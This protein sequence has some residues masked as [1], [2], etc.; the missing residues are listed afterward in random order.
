MAESKLVSTKA[1]RG[2]HGATGQPAEYYIQS[3]GPTPADVVESIDRAF[4]VIERAALATITQMENAEP[5][6]NFN[7]FTEAMASLAEFGVVSKRPGV[8]PILKFTDLKQHKSNKKVE[9]APKVA[10]YLLAI[11]AEGAMHGIK[12]TVKSSFRTKAEQQGLYTK[13][14][15]RKKAQVASRE[16]FR[17]T[18]AGDPP[19]GPLKGGREKS[20]QAKGDEDYR[21]ANGGRLPNLAAPPGRSAHEKGLAFDFKV[22]GNSGKGGKVSAA[23][24]PYSTVGLDTLAQI[25]VKYG[26]IRTVWPP[27]ARNMR[28][29][30]EPWHF[31]FNETMFDSSTIST[32]MGQAT[33]AALN[34]L[35]DEF[36]K[37]RILSGGT[38]DTEKYFGLSAWIA[39]LHKVY[40]RV[41]AGT[42]TVKGNTRTIYATEAAK[43][44]KRAARENRRLKNEAKRSLATTKVPVTATEKHIKATHTY[45]DREKHEWVVGGK[46]VSNFSSKK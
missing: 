33:S 5:L 1:P 2:T 32:D 4:A 44:A 22:D 42:S 28:G 39:R 35:L 37:G 31:A 12:V 41:I 23:V 29:Y 34:L 27:H 24:P 17:D 9:C 26:F 6:A 30:L 46:A 15:N 43:E 19:T 10:P 16:E 36:S 3:S 21:A 7:A 20:A 40:E 38:K 13:W 25:A 11:I 18:A 8:G 45:Y 14:L